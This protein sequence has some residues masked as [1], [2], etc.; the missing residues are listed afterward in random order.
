[1]A[2]K[3]SIAEG[4]SLGS[5]GYGMRSVKPCEFEETS[6]RIMCITRERENLTSI[7][8]YSVA[9]LPGRVQPSSNKQKTTVFFYGFPEPKAML[10]TTGDGRC[11]CAT[12]EVAS[13]RTWADWRMPRWA[14]Y[15]IHDAK[16]VEAMYRCLE[17][18]LLNGRIELW[19]AIQASQM[20]ATYAIKNRL[21]A[22]SDA[23][24]RVHRPS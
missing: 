4:R 8:D 18:E 10:R 3:P 20:N 21:K 19:E 24:R 16:L 7:A 13:I 9:T 15:G 2:S 5:R 12:G 17:M 11:T 1:M 14:N 6:D 23:S 22:M